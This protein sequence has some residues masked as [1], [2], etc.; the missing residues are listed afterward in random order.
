[1]ARVRPPFDA[2]EVRRLA[3]TWGVQAAIESAEARATSRA[4]RAGLVE[5]IDRMAE[6]RVGLQRAAA[7]SQERRLTP[8]ECELATLVAE[9]LTNAEI[10][11]RLVLRPGTVGNHLANIQRRLGARNRV[12]VAVWAV[13]Q[14]LY[15][16]AR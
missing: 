11:E 10:A 7:R 6:A 12:Q 14:G 13:E 3:R 1:V 8:R 5:A 4:V 9:G 2:D 15:R 16:S